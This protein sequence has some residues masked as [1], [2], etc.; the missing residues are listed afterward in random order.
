LKSLADTIDRNRN[1]SYEVFVDSFAGY[2]TIFSFTFDDDENVP[3]PEISIFMPQ[4][5]CDCTKR[6]S[7]CVTCTKKVVQK[8]YIINY[9]VPG[10]TMVI[11]VY[12]HAL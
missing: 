12:Y 6:S 11:V 4:A 7:S 9:E 10:E 2:N 8:F 5:Q 3:P 1:K